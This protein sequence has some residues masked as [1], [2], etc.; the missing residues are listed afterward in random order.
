MSLPYNAESDKHVVCRE[1]PRATY[2]SVL[3]FNYFVISSVKYLFGKFKNCIKMAPWLH[4][5]IFSSKWGHRNQ[6]RRH[7][8]VLWPQMLDVIAV[9]PTRQMHGRNLTIRIIDL[10]NKLLYFGVQYLGNVKLYNR[11]C[12]VLGINNIRPRQRVLI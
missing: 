5:N 11:W 8:G 7:F 12:R 6:K 1:R 4:V 3:K 10:L 9:A 2:L